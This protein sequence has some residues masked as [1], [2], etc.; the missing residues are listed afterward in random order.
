MDELVLKVAAARGIAPAVTILAA[1]GARVG[2]ACCSECGAA[3][4]LD[5]RESIDVV[6]LHNEWHAALR[7][8]EA[9]P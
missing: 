6:Y 5:P 8:N 4:L 3:L 7:R 9:R 1:E 2:I